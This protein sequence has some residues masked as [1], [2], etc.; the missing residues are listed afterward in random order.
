MLNNLKAKEQA[1]SK[2][3]NMIQVQKGANNIN[4]SKKWLRWDFMWDMIVF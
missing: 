4:S 3:L 2:K 1:L